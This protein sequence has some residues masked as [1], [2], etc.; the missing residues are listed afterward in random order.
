[1]AERDAILLVDDDPEVI[2]L[3]GEHLEAEGYLV[4]VARTG[5]DGLRL[6]RE[7]PVTLLLLDLVLPDM[8]GLNLMLEARG[9]PT[10]PEVV[11][12]TGYASLETAIEAVEGSA[13]GYI[14][15]PVDLGRLS[16]IVGRVIER[17]RLLRENAELQ[18]ALQGRL[19][20][21]EA[22]AAVSASVSSTLDVREAL[23]RAGRELAR[24]LGAGTVAAY[25]PARDAARPGPPA[26]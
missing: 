26:R 19:A 18:K 22:L 25:P 13:A 9:L 24:L 1:M 12:V 6:L 21:S 5:G 14:V 11:I 23:R 15:K 3:L 4:L 17:R 20:E 8:G 16:I 7:R 2:R 10:P